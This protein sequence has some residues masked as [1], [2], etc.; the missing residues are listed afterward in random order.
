MKSE[1][2]FRINLFEAAF[3]FDFTYLIL[4]RCDVRLSDVVKLREVIREV[5]GKHEEI[6]VAYLYGSTVKGYSGKTS[7]VDVGLLLE[8]DFQPGP[9]Y[10]AR[11]A[12]EIREECGLD[13]EVDVRVLNGRSYRFLHQVIKE[14]EVVFSK[15]E[16]ERV[17]FETSVVDAYIDFKPFYDQYD[18]KRRER[19]LA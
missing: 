19:L 9:L 13:R 3:K 14:G 15:D 18:E 16:K 11:L 10:P 8:E 12:G 6:L 2:E 4:K 17:R 1:Y 5:L 7:D